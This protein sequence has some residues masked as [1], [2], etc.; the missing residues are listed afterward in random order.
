MQNSLHLVSEY[1][2]TTTITTGTGTG[3]ATNMNALNLQLARTLVHAGC[4]LNHRDYLSHETPIFRAITANNYDL[5]KYM[6]CEGVDMSARNSFGNDVLS[7]SIQ[8]GR[9]RIA[10]LLIVADS[11]IRVYSCIYRIPHADD[12]TRGNLAAAATSINDQQSLA[13]DANDLDLNELNSENFL[14][15]S[16]AKYEEFLAFLQTYTQRPRSLLDLSRL[17]VRNQMRKPVSLFV[18][19]LGTLP[20]SIVDLVLLKDIDA[21]VI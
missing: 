20:Q 17:C 5:V 21:K 12:L 15:Y 4:D 16:I 18:H 6:V 13:A 2:K 3:A 11:P 8:L 1:K 7:R 9:F 14:Q 19:K 10:R